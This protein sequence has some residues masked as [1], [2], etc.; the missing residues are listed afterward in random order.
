MYYGEVYNNLS[1]Q[2][3]FKIRK[4]VDPYCDRE[5]TL[6]TALISGLNDDELCSAF[7]WWW[8]LFE[9]YM[10]NPRYEHNYAT[11]QEEM[12]RRHLC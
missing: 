4:K 1:D 9:L 10:D 2:E 7:E 3:F 11:L 8:S 5:I 6:T 12:K